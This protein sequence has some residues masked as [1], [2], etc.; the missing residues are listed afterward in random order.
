[1]VLTFPVLFIIRRDGI[2]AFDISII[3]N[4]SLNN[5]LEACENLK[6]LKPEEPLSISIEAYCKNNMFFIEVINTFDGMIRYEK[7]DDILLTR[8]ENYFEHGLGF[9][10]IRKCAE[11][12][13]G[14]A[15]YSYEAKQFCVTVMLQK[16]W[17]KDGGS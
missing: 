6:E 9:Q 15:E 1:M 8:K 2:S 17:E 5:A 3:L 14:S 10:N 13:L 16:V 7:K 12:Y 4:N 11:K